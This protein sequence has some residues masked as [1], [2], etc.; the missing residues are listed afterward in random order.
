MILLAISVLS[1]IFR[2]SEGVMYR[3]FEGPIVQGFDTPRVRKSEGSIIRFQ[4]IWNW[5]WKVRY[6]AKTMHACVA[7]L[8]RQ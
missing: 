6:E 4:G 3:K 7:G 8:Q 1:F 5:S 2:Y